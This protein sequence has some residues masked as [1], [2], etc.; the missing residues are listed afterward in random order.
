[1][2]PGQRVAACRGDG[3]P[4]IVRLAPDPVEQPE[5][6]RQPRNLPPHRRGG[7]LPHPG[8]IRLLGA[9]LAE[10]HEEWAESHRYLSLEVLA[11]AQAVGTGTEEDDQ[12]ALQALTA[13]PNNY[14]GSERVHLKGLARRPPPP[15]PPG[16]RAGPRSGSVKMAP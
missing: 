12:P 2:N 13:W 7:D 3:H 8:P 1:M 4:V 5:Q 15:D 14:K 16:P 9:V 11:R 10:Q 6:A